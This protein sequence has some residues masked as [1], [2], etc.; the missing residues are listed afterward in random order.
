MPNPLA[1]LVSH[2]DADLDA[3]FAPVRTAIDQELAKDRPNLPQLR[4][5]V[6]ASLTDLFG[7]DAAGFAASRLGAYTQGALDAA[8]TVGRGQPST[9]TLGGVTNGSTT[10]GRMAAAGAHLAGMV[11]ANL[12]YF[13][14]LPANGQIGKG[15]VRR[16]FREFLSVDGAANSIGATGDHGLY[17]ARRTLVTEAAREYGGG[18]EERAAVA[19]RPLRWELDPRHPRADVCDT[20]AT[21]D[22][23][24]LGAGVYPAGKLPRF[25]AHPHCICHIVIVR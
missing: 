2:I 11:D 15:D 22:N 25:P 21:A 18:V 19:G 9:A 20:H 1:A 24:G 4:R 14:A 17:E 13:A 8:R 23:Y 6:A 12:R 5:R 3:L 16:F 7:E 10:P